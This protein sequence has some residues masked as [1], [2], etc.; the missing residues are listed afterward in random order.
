ML[1][2]MLSIFSARAELG[3]LTAVLIGLAAMLM[4]MTVGA[5]A[6][7]V[8]DISPNQASTGLVYGVYNGAL[9]IMGAVN[10]LI[11]A[12]I[13][14][15]FGFPAAFAS[16]ILFMLIFMISI[17]FIVDRPSYTKLIAR[18]ELARGAA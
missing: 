10:S 16:A 14:T 1:C 8:I 2:M 9:N 5:W 3:G 15:R 7:N 11:L 4:N 13:A 6:V 18:A 12:W 17:L